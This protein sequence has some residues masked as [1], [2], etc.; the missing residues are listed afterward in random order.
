M[1]ARTIGYYVTTGLA[2]FAMVGSGMGDLLQAEPIVEAVSQK[3]GYP[4]Y[5]L[6]WLGFWK[7]AGV[8]A[9]WAPTSIGAWVANAK[10]WAYAGLVL[11]MVGASY[12]HVMTNDVAGAPPTAVLALLWVGSYVLRSR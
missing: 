11:S 1:N 3:L 7:I 12:S 9:V 8:V 6:P 5:F 2:S 10:E 4:L